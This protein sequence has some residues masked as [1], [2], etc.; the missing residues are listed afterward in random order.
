M[1]E[2]KAV[3]REIIPKLEDFTKT[4]QLFDF[5]KNTRRDQTGQSFS[6][7]NHNM[8]DISMRFEKIFELKGRDSTSPK[9]QELAK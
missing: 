7:A 9:Y 1:L 3:F 4:T 6:F 5:F 2:Y 8:K